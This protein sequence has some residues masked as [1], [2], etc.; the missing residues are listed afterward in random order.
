MRI[1]VFQHLTVEHPGIFREFWAEAGHQW[2]AV[3]L[4]AQGIIPPLQPYDLL[5][6]MGGPMDVWETD[7]HPWLLPEIAAI[8]YWVGALKR[9]YLGIC[10]GH[11]LL[12]V[13][14]GGTV[15]LMPAPEVG[16]AEVALTEAGCTDKLLAG[17]PPRLETFQW[18]G[19]EVKTLPE[20]AVVLAGN[21]ACTVQAMRVGP[22]AWGFQYHVEITPSTVAE[23]GAVPEYAASLEQ[24]LGA[25][26]AAQLGGRVAARLPMFG[27]AARRLN[28]NLLGILTPAL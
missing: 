19:A 10:L 27:A 1:L 22:H 23:W 17:F 25:E 12:A 15:G 13:A 5:V 3:E 16:L 14:M 2:E 28:D 24:A 26:M 11:Q 21:D 7:K 20:S 18:H 9:P 4:D 8:R 6:V